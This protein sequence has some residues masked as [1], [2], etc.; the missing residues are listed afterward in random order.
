MFGVKEKCSLMG[1]IV[2][3]PLIVKVPAIGMG[4]RT[5]DAAQLSLAQTAERSTEVM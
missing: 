4:R 2:A 1:K 5:L 3:E